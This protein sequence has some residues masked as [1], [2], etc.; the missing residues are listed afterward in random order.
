MSFEFKK[1]LSPEGDIFEGLYEIFPDIKGDD[2]GYFMEAYK[3]E[4]FCKAGLTM[5]FV[6]ENQ[7][8]SRKGVLRGLHFQTRH[9]Q[10][11][12]LN[13]IEGKVFDLALD[14]RNDSLTFGRY[15]SLILDS[16]K[17]NQFY[18]PKGFAHGFYVLSEGAL[19]QYKCT[20]FYDPKG[21]GG[22]IWNDPQLGIDWK[23]LNMG[24]E[25]ILSEKDQTLPFFDFNKKYF[26]IKGNW[27]GD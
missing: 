9:P 25:V 24:T 18:I 8:Y 7:S 12:L 13:V 27:I 17:K 15:H 2:R 26:D 23:S 6:Q 20:D 16:K 22:I 11:K 19:F 3:K 10:G 5:E 21:E 14:L 4:D 1:C